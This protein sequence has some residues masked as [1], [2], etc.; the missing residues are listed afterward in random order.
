[1]SGGTRAVQLAGRSFPCPCHAC[2]FFHEREEEYRILLPFTA[3]GI[4]AGDRSFQILDRAQRAE[5]RQ[6]LGEAGIDTEDAERRSQLELR[7]RQA[8][9]S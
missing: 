4:Q 9:A 5:R 2:A 6:R 7:H 1:M 3:A 8:Q